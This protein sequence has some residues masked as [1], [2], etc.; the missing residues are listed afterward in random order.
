MI[1]ILVAVNK[2][3]HFL[4]CLQK[5]VTCLEKIR[6]DNCYRQRHSLLPD[7]YLIYNEFR[8]AEYLMRL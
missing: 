5:K 8:Q 7:V 2:E 4:Q 3:C 6:N 1:V